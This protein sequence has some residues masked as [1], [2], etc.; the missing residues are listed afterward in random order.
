M[1]ASL[2]VLVSLTACQH[3][4]TPSVSPNA[5]TPS[6]P[7][8]IVNTPTFADIAYGAD[9]AQKLDIYLPK[10]ANA[11]T[12]LV[13]N[14]HGG[15]WVTGSKNESAHSPRDIHLLIKALLDKGFAVASVE[16][17]FAPKHPIN[18]QVLDVN[19]AVDFLRA[20]AKQ[21]G[22][23]SQKMAVMGQSAGGQLSQMVAVTQGVG[24]IRA[25]VAF[26]APSDVVNLRAYPMNDPQCK[27]SAVQ[28]LKRFYGEEKA[29]KLGLP[30]DEGLLL[31]E[32][33]DTPAFVEK[34]RQVSPVYR[35]YANTPPALLFHGNQDC[36]VPHKH[37]QVY[38]NQ[39]QIMGVESEL[40]VVDGAGHAQSAFFNT[41][42]YQQKVVAFLDKQLNKE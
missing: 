17:R 35:I 28:A 29:Q 31:G 38:F 22:F 32:R 41:P 24:K 18:E 1:T 26:Y 19:N 4:P 27:M 37:S 2:C 5:H 40:V 13:V 6:T 15:G 9:P 7:A 34:A 12:P 14:I 10:N 8:K 3:L 20:N 11:D 33:I 36:I 25:N 23:N 16:Y 39:L 21:Y 30:D 42:A